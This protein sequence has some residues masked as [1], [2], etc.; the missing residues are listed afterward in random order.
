M[1]PVCWVVCSPSEPA[2]QQINKCKKL[3]QQTPLDKT[4][5]QDRGT[6][7]TAATFWRCYLSHSSTFVLY[8]RSH[9][10]LQF[11]KPIICVVLLQLYEGAWDLG[12][13]G[14]VVH[15]GGY[16]LTTSVRSGALFKVGKKLCETVGR[17]G[18]S[19]RHR[20]EEN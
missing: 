18:V 13:N 16:I 4:L 6:F 9:V 7:V 20:S 8:F 19:L 10:F 12:L 14:I 2:E 1:V 3:S 11:Y 15:F 17:S 5:W